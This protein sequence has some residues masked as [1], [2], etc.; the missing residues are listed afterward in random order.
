MPGSTDYE[1]GILPDKQLEERVDA[2]VRCRDG[3][4]DSLVR[5]D[6]LEKERRMGMTLLRRVDDVAVGGGGVGGGGGGGG[7]GGGGGGGGGAMGSTTKTT[8]SSTSGTRRSSRFEGRETDAA[9]SRRGRD[10]TE[11]PAKRPRG[12]ASASDVRPSL[13]AGVEYGGD[14]DE[15]Y[16]DDECDGDYDDASSES[17]MPHDRTMSSERIP[18]MQQRKHAQLRRKAT[19]AYHTMNKKKLVDICRIEGLSTLGNEAELR[20]R[21]SDYITLYN[22]ECDSEH[23]RSVGALLNEIRSREISIK[24]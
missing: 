19:V 22:S 15:D 2:Y 20:Q 3:M 16:D 14:N 12:R 18:P 11:R 10:D 24:V 5:L 8:A 23:P 17:K 9:R 6:V 21:H 4:R 1:R 7:R 13:L